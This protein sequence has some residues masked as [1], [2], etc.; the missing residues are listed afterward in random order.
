VE[1]LQLAAVEH[2]E[3]AKAAARI[4]GEAVAEIVLSAGIE[5]QIFAHLRPSRFQKPDQPAVMVE[6]PMTE[7]QRVHP[8]GSIFNRSRFLA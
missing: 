3:I 8:A 6:V 1:R 5:A 2:A 7:E 4:A